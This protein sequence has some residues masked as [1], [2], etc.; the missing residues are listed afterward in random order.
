MGNKRIGIFFMLLGFL[1][2][3][4]L[5][6]N[7]GRQREDTEEPKAN[8]TVRPSKNTKAVGNLRE[9]A[10]KNIIICVLD[11]ARPDHMGCYGY[12]RPTTPN[13]DRLAK[14]SLVFEQHY[15]PYPIT[16]QSTRALFESR[17]VVPRRTQSDSLVESLQRLGFNTIFLAA[18]PRITGIIGALGKGFDNIG[19]DSQPSAAD[20]HRQMAN[21][22]RADN[23][24]KSKEDFFYRPQ[25]LLAQ[26]NDWLATKPKRPFFTYIHFIPPHVP[27][28]APK[29]LKALFLGKQ[30]PAY[31]KSAS[32]MPTEKSDKPLDKQPSAMA[33]SVNE[34]LNLYDANMRWA[35]GAVGALEQALRKAGLFDNTLLIIMA[36]HGEALGEHGYNWHPDCPYDEALHIPMIMRFPGKG[37]PKGRVKALTHTID[38]LPT[39]FDLHNKPWPAAAQG[40]SLLPLLA[41]ATARTHDYC[42]SAAGSVSLCRTFI[43][44]DLQTTLL[45]NEDGKTRA[46]YDM[47][48]DPH[49]S[50]NV[51]KSEPARAARLVE[52]FRRFA[53]AQPYP[54][55][56]FIDPKARRKAVKSSAE[57]QTKNMP[58]KLRKQLGTLGYLK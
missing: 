47:V 8:K 28:D 30:P 53:E 48:K 11:A 26:V 37:A 36:D 21:I 55:L 46:L 35:D 18:N 3:V 22:V 1:I 29:D 50:K 2:I 27:Y 5:A 25:Y 19:A 20:R 9:A 43:V 23:T 33:G 40:R 14:D 4:F 38:L 51:I 7:F 15:C 49:Q 57:P 42:F 17:Y 44:R 39:L 31:W 32:A 34:T 56:N 6:G 12:P 41:G 52:A 58:E 54:P 24:D 10:G 13:I 16:E 45:L